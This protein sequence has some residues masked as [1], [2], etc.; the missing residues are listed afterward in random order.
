LTPTTR[1][2]AASVPKTRLILRR[3]VRSVV[4][5]LTAWNITFAETENAE[6]L[7]ISSSPGY[8]AV[9]AFPAQRLGDRT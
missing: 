7:I 6:R 8:S 5:R 3:L 1:A 9:R 4:S 2:L